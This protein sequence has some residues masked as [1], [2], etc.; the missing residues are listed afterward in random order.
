MPYALTV[1]QQGFIQAERLKN[2]PGISWLHY[3][4]VFQGAINEDCL[5]N[6]LKDVLN[7]HQVLTCK[8]S[9][10][11]TQL[12]SDQTEMN[13]EHFMVSDIN[14]KQE[15]NQ[16]IYFQL[17]AEHERCILQIK[18]HHIVFDDFSLDVF[19]RHL[20]IFY[21]AVQHNKPVPALSIS[22]DFTQFMAD[23]NMAK[24]RIVVE[25]K[26]FQNILPFK[27]SKKADK[28][29]HQPADFSLISVKAL[30]NKFAHYKENIIFLAVFLNLLKYYGLNE[31][32]ISVPFS[33]RARNQDS[34][35][36]GY[37]AN[38]TVLHFSSLS[39]INSFEELL[40]VVNAKWQTAASNKNHLFEAQYPDVGIPNIVFCWQYARQKT[41][42]FVNGCE[43][44]IQYSKNE[45]PR[46]DIGI[47]LRSASKGEGAIYGFLECNPNVVP[48]YVAQNM[49]KHFAVMV[50]QLC[51]DNEIPIL[52]Q[53]EQEQLS[54]WQPSPG[55][56]SV[57]KTPYAIIIE[58]LRVHLDDIV[59][60]D[61]QAH[62]AQDLIHQSNQVAQYLKQQQVG[63]KDVCALNINGGF[64]L[65]SMILGI[66][67]I[68]AVVFILDPR[69]TE[70]QVKSRL[71][72]SKAKICLSEKH[73]KNINAVN[74]SKE[75]NPILYYEKMPCYIATSSGTT[76]AP[77]VMLLP[78]EA[79]TKWLILQDKL[80]SWHE[81]GKHEH[82]LLTTTLGFDAA[83]WDMFRALSF[84][85]TLHF[86]GADIID[87]TSLYQYV[88]ANDI[89]HL[90]MA[91]QQLQQLM[92][93]LKLQDTV[94]LN[95]KVVTTGDKLPIK[96]AKLA[97]K[98]GITIYNGYGET[99]A[100]IGE[101]LAEYKVDSPYFSSALPGMQ[102][103]ILNEAMQPVPPGTI[104]SLYVGG[105]GLMLQR[106]DDPAFA[107][108]IH[109][110]TGQPLVN[111]QMLAYFDECNALQ[112]IGRK[113]RAIKFN[114]Q[115]INL[116]GIENTLMQHTGVSL[117]IVLFNKQDQQIEAYLQIDQ[118]ESFDLE[119]LYTFLQEQ[120]PVFSVPH[121]FWQ[122]TQ[123][124]MTNRGKLDTPTLKL[125]AQS[126]MLPSSFVINSDYVEVAEQKLLVLLDG[127]KL[128]EDWLSKGYALLGLGSLQWA[129]FVN[130][131]FQH[132]NIQTS[133]LSESIEFKC[134]LSSVSFL[135]EKLQEHRNVIL[136]KEQAQ[137]REDKPENEYLPSEFNPF[138]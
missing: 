97:K 70:E 44:D 1:A 108:P 89:Q 101:I 59:I 98:Y 52:T 40:D 17:T 57:K 116:E 76:G 61:Q 85:S 107:L 138:G 113:D 47:D 25:K 21:Q 110:E 78:I 124:P 87:P 18:V 28:I 41:M 128:P 90:T 80:P 92:N 127:K 67:K 6:A 121:Q 132:F 106:L 129:S 51:Q 118:T 62:T 71:Q 100:G 34:E 16:L 13:I 115:M 95:I 64:D 8:L 119:L 79:L 102:L 33:L 73:L 69:L 126:L 26:S 29:F 112:L 91:P 88:H 125:N 66:W 38:I 46:F 48:T 135:L 4:L 9:T 114:G 42:K 27:T 49:L 32:Y 105:A 123:L 137:P 65:V 12:E 22:R 96:L 131:M 30:K 3:Q 55:I 5:R 63:V 111:T 72:I 43:L 82:L 130:G 53:L 15:T 83:L 50:D 31:L 54:H 74:T 68:G 94:N 81:Q 103:Y 7:I 104:G 14:I 37:Y 24:E 109:P 58:R 120:L 134:K 77:K 122:I 86:A 56:D 11:N 93:F 2:S 19:I 75:L 117:A 35:S 36:I 84:G 10:D 23:L 45:Y 60:V 136:L 99:E 133:A 39:S 20:K